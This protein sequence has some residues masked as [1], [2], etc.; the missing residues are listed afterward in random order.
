M[1]M[2][3]KTGDISL[4]SAA[5][6]ASYAS[7]QNTRIKYKMEDTKIQI[8]TGESASAAGRSRHYTDDSLPHV[9]LLFHFFVIFIHFKN[10]DWSSTLHSRYFTV[11]QRPNACFLCRTSWF[12]FLSDYHWYVGHVCQ[13]CD[14][15]RGCAVRLL[16]QF[17]W[18]CFG[19]LE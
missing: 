8:Q 5:G 3:M 14:D 9:F 6:D 19:D 13:D 2:V 12:L 18:V 17:Q 10:N 11:V 16:W 7:L 1:D 15:M 4:M